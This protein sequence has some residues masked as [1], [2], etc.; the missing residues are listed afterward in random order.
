[1]INIIFR[2]IF[3]IFLVISSTSCN[4]TM[5]A[6]DGYP[7]EEHTVET[8]D[9]FCLKLFRIPKPGKEVVFLQHGKA[10]DIRIF[11]C[12][13]FPLRIACFVN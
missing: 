10:K 1:M 6:N 2:S 5:I 11:S 7:V 13:I 4:K 3:T 12:K 9:G 8:E